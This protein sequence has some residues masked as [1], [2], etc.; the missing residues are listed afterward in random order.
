MQVERAGPDIEADCE[1]VL[2]SL[3]KWFGIEA[4]LVEYVRD[5]SLMPTFVTRRGGVIDG[6]LTLRKHFAPSLE[7]HCI[8]VHPASRGTG[9]GRALVAH[10]E[11]WVRREGGRFL[12][13]KTVD[14]SG[15]SA[16]YDETR[17]FY[18]HMGF[19]PLEVFPTLWDAHNPCLQMVKH[20]P[21]GR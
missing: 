6:F 3:P 13:V 20:L 5:S 16:A 9:R 14:A 1:R 11:E 18:E 12:Q 4:A 21:G 15:H 19:V 7:I 2:R 10:V 8:A 17:G